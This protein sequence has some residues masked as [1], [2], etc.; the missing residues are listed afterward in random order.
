MYQN[1]ISLNHAQT[2]SRD[3]QH[4]PQSSGALWIRARCETLLD[5]AGVP[6][7]TC[8]SPKDRTRRIS[9]PTCSVIP[10]GI[11]DSR[12]DNSVPMLCCR[13]V[14]SYCTTILAGTRIPNTIG[15]G[16]CKE[17]TQEAE[18]GVEPTASVRRSKA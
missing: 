15:V 7:A 11:P 2:N 8:G 13:P 14:Q 5:Q 4:L 1:K 6:G 17:I 10:P 16:L 9:P 18:A 12:L 3:K